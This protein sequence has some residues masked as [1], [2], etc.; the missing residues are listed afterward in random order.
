MTATYFRANFSRHGLSDIL[1]LCNWHTRGWLGKRNSPVYYCGGRRRSSKKSQATSTAL[2]LCHCLSFVALIEIIAQWRSQENFST[3]HD[4]ADFP[5][6]GWPLHSYT[7]TYLPW[8]CRNNR[9]VQDKWSIRFPLS[10]DNCLFGRQKHLSLCLASWIS[11]GT[12]C[13]WAVLKI[14]QLPL[15][16]MTFFPQKEAILF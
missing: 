5:L 13:K 15:P 2:S 11:I 16:T 9:V 12:L 14:G 1:C 6:A 4:G 7:E 3:V 8:A 10:F